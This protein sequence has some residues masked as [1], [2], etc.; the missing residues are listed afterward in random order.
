MVYLIIDI[1]LAICESVLLSNPS[2][3]S[4]VEIKGESS[5]SDVS[6]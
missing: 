4:A 5:I 6:F 3:I 2:S 1:L